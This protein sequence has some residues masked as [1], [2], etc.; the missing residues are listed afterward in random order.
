MMPAASRLGDSETDARAAS[1]EYEAPYL[2]EKLVKDRVCASEHEARALFR[3][4]K[5]FLYLNRTDRSRV[6]D[7]V[8]HRVDEVWHQFVLFTLQYMEFC[9]RHYGIYLPHA[10]SNAPKPARGGAP[11]VPTAT[12]AEF[13]ARYETMYGEPLP[14]CWHDDRSV[15]LNRRVIDTRIGHLLMRQTE[16]NLELVNGDGEVVFAVNA[17][18]EPAMTFIAETGAFYVRELPGG[19]TDEEKVAL[20]ATLVQHRFLRVGG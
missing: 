1:L 18:A 9:E 7:M 17:I 13:A 6:W 4:V 20:V 2:I 19:L 15:G 14:D 3:E 10:P 11:D 16:G 12:F 5:R 8:S